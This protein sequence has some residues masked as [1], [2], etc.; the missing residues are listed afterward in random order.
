VVIRALAF[1]A[2]AAFIFGCKNTYKGGKISEGTDAFVGLNVP[3]SEGT[4][5][6]E[7]L[8]YLSGFRFAYDK[9]AEIECWYATT[10]ETHFCGV[11]D[12]Y[13]VKNFKIKMTPLDRGT[14]DAEETNAVIRIV[15][16]I[17]FENAPYYMCTTNN[18]MLL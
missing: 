17:Q 5:Q 13:V 18:I 15:N 16:P 4:I 7:V 9:D 6:F 11:Y 1:A 8:N 12:N 14:Q 3:L 2:V 10:N